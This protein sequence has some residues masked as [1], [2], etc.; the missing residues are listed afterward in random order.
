VIEVRNA[1]GDRAYSFTAQL[2]RRFANGTEIGASYTYSRSRDRLSPNADNTDG[3]V[4]F[5]ALDGSLEHRRLATAL[6]NVPHRVT[7]LATANLPFGFRAALFYE[8][9]SGTPFT[10]TVGGDA[11]ADGFWEDDIMYVPANPVPGGDIELAVFDE[12]T[13]EFLPAPAAEYDALARA[14]EDQPCLRAQRG[15]IMR[16]NSCRAPWSNH[17]D[18]R[19][20]RVFS[21]FQGHALELTLDVF[22]LLHLLDADWGQ[23]RGS[24]G[25]L[26]ELVGYDEPLGR[27]V[28]HRVDAARAFVDQDG[29]RWRMQLGARYTF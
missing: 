3:D 6:W 12:A 14:I 9:L 23:L 2:Q 4:D 20:S 28:Y 29:S 18:A 17:A 1:R 7:L 26:L 24:D 5:T 16:R 21:T 10:Y 15:R 13:G 27:G 19:L 11:N 22:N 8:G 25:S